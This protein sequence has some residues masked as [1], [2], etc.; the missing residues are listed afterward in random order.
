MFVA[1]WHFAG[2][3]LRYG[4]SLKG[5]VLQQDGATRA[6]LPLAN[7]GE[8]SRS[9]YLLTKSCRCNAFFIS[10]SKALINSKYILSKDR[11][12]I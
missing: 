11:F 9:V 5:I 1:V 8:E 10:Q 6:P 7:E 3:H 12:I 4:S 2:V